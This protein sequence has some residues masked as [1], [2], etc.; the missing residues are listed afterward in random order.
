LQPERVK[1]VLKKANVYAAYYPLIRKDWRV[2]YTS[3]IRVIRS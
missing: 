3:T 2:V 1:F